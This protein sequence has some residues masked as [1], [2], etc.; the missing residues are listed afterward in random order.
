M[1]VAW[2]VFEKAEGRWQE[3]FP[4]LGWGCC[5]GGMGFGI[6]GHRRDA[7]ATLLAWRH[8]H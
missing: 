7:R 4:N 3:A 1:R 5:W 6:E 2:A 8:L